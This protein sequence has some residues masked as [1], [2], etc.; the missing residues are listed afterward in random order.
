MTTSKVFLLIVTTTALAGAPARVV[1]QGASPEPLVEQYLR[2]GRLAEGEKALAAHLRGNPSDDH[3]RFGLGTLQFLRSVERLMQSLHTYGLRS[4]ENELTESLPFA[5]LPVPPNPN[6]ETM[7]YDALRQ[8]AA[9]WISGVAAAEGTLAQ[10]KSNDV[11]LPLKFGLIRLD[12]N[13]DG[14][15]AEEETLWRIFVRVQ[16]GGAEIDDDGEIQSAPNAEG[17]N[18]AAK[19]EQFVIS[20]DAG[21]VQWLRG[22]CHLL[23]ALAEVLLAHDERELFD[24]TAHLFFQKVQTPFPYLAEGRRVADFGM[25]FDI[26][27]AIAFVHLIRFPVTEPKRMAAARDH[28]QEMLRRSRDS[29]TLIQAETDDDREWIPNAKQATVIP[30]VRVSQ[31][32]IDSWMQFLDEGEAL[33]EGKRL[34]PFWRGAGQR[35][36]NLKRVFTE[37]SPLDLVLWIQGSAAAPYLEEGELTRQDVWSNMARAFGGNL[38][39]FAVWFN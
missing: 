11:K 7:T 20:F 32:M 13:G 35:G 39:G 24:A 25:G 12:F 26:A 4:G 29:W 33:L 28:L 23:M 19:A 15:A 14:T 5:R 30:N 9:D 8:I 17:G 16:G 27:D 38:F 21:D 10:I 18:A 22:Y 3:A 2:S 1:A 37:P 31:E 6:P 34:A 36:V